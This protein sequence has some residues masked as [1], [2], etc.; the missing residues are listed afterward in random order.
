M[1]GLPFGD[2]YT[3]VRSKGT[4]APSASAASVDRPTLLMVGVGD[5][6]DAALKLALDRRGLFVETVGA[7]ELRRSVHLTAP[8]LILLVGDAAADGGV[9]ALGVLAEDPSTAAVPVALLAPDDKLESRMHA[10]RHGAMAV[11]P[12][13]ASADGI[14]QRVARLSKEMSTHFEEK[15]GEI[16]EA[17]F[18]ELVEL[19]KQELRS[20]ILSVHA[21]G[22]KGGP[23]RV[24]LGAGRPVAQAVEEFVARLRPHVTAAD[25]MYYQFHTS[26][27][28]PVELLDGEGVPNADLSVLQKLRLLLVDDDPVRAD[29]LAQELRSRGALVFVT[30]TT[31]RGIERAVGLDPQ[32]AIVDAAGLEGPGFEV[33]RA[34]RKDHRL[35]WASILV[36]P[37]DEV[38]PR[39]APSPDVEQLASRIQ[40]L[41]APEEDLAKRTAEEESFDVR[42]ESTGPSRMLRI[43]VESGLTL[44]L[45]VRNPRAVIELDL[46]QNLL[47]GAE[48][49]TT[50]GEVHHGA[51]ALALLLVLGSGR[52]H[53]ERRANPSVANV[54]SP[55]EE[56]LSTAS[57]E[58]ISMP[59]SPAPR[60]RPVRSASPPK[61]TPMSQDDL[62]PIEEDE[63][64]DHAATQV[65]DLSKL[66]H[67]GEVLLDDHSATVRPPQPP[68]DP[69]EAVPTAWPPAIGGGPI[70]ARERSRKPARRM[71]T[72]VMGAP[73]PVPSGVREAQTKKASGGRRRATGR[74]KK[75]LMGIHPEKPPPLP[76]A[77][78][79]QTG[80]APASSPRADAQARLGGESGSGS[81][82]AMEGGKRAG[83]AAEV[84]PPGPAAPA[85]SEGLTSHAA[86]A[87]SVASQAMS[88]ESVVSESVSSEV[89]DPATSEPASAQ[90][91]P[92][93]AQATSAA[94][95]SASR[96]WSDGVDLPPIGDPRDPA[97]EPTLLTRR[98]SSGAWTKVLIGVASIGLLSVATLLGYR[99]SGFHVE[100]LDRAL[101]IF[102]MGS[103]AAD[104]SQAQRGANTQADRSASHGSGTEE[105]SRRGATAE[106]L[107]AAEDI[108]AGGDP[109]EDGSNEG[110]PSGDE[111]PDDVPAWTGDPDEARAGART[112]DEASLSDSDDPREL[113]A[114]ARRAGSSD[115]AEAL[116]RRVLVLDPNEHHAMVGLG[117]LLMER[118]RHADAIEPLRGAVQ[119]RRRRA[120]Y[121][122]WL[123]DALAGAGDRAAAM[124]EWRAALE[125][126][127]NNAQARRRL[128]R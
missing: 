103:R 99:F 100:P 16:G 98:R 43:L 53:V 108:V 105:V 123:G 106:P 35:R 80:A 74:L 115:L 66:A 47:V 96:A 58:D 36:A 120:A 48:A 109:T 34:I 28:G 60:R 112:D 55:V 82:G 77:S 52:V 104:S 91:N 101:A 75:T 42:L 87:E 49:R 118:N 73:P 64:K 97:R 83:G 61:S 33:V 119:R 111:G 85:T 6:M 127:P 31:G 121:R 46:A 93:A 57:A 84:S 23:M 107:D 68:V 9:A 51:M 19:V 71:P 110:E 44:H 126:E 125:I 67:A 13:T 40:P 29:T 25:P 92:T 18:D 38:W 90:A 113:L 45:T 21:P 62:I 70:D 78:S 8:D 59:E 20:G 2:T 72:L 26:A 79:A 117:R 54:M 22:H 95:G 88:S 24:V 114:R 124:E 122:V 81:A 86:T 116:Y 128:G 3:R 4:S 39:G 89:A 76:S 94:D 7:E 63:E 102:D 14:A 41:L 65:K 32:I 10:F 69:K 50:E 15:T 30:D 17:T 37:W 27:G 12:R 1:C 5:P 11:V 56:A